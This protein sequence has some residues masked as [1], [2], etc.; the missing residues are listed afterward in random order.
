MKSTVNR[1][2]VT[3]KRH[4]R[5]RRKLSGTTESPRLS[6]YRSGKHI[7]AQVI[8]D[9]RQVTLASA[10]SNDKDLRE[11]IGSGANLEAA[12]KVGEAVA[13]RAQ[14]AGITSV[15]FDRGGNLYHGRIQVLADAAREA[16]LKF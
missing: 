12:R 1:K 10:S 7:Y 2:E 6:V 8:D 9:T 14:K 5:L 15:V 3:R 16:G 4:Y 13:Q 11:A